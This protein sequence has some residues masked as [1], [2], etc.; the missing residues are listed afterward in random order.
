MKKRYKLLNSQG[1]IMILQWVT[2]GVLFGPCWE[3]MMV[4]DENEENLKRCKQIV[5]LI[6]ECDMHTN[7]PNND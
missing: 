4:F 1:K 5:R 6:N 2:K 7:H 3:S